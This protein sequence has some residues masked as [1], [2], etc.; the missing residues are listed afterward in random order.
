MRQK[1]AAGNWKMN[2]TL[3]EGVE[4]VKKLVNSSRHNKTLT[5]LG[6][7][8]THLAEIASMLRYVPNI[9]VAAQNC[10]N[11]PSGAY[12]GEISPTM[13][14]SLGVNYVILGHSERRQHFNESN[15]VLK[16]K[17]DLALAN[18]LK[19]I[20]CCGE[21]LKTRKAKKHVAF[22][23][24]QLKE[25]L[26]HLKATHLEN[27]IIAYEPIWAIGTGETATPKQAQEMHKAILPMQRKY[28]SREILMEDSL[29]VLP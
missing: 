3:D 12:T 14:N 29:V 18:G 10:S 8:F 6:V 1:I 17:L 2:L 20:F 13:I 19:V 9:E 15:E 28:F 4:L 5:I 16:E 7:P 22:V 26:M 11:R 27:V 25:S 21:T 23:T 24:N